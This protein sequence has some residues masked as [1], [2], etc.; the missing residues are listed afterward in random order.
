MGGYNSINQGQYSPPGLRA[1]LFA[2]LLVAA[3]TAIGCA[4]IAVQY[5]EG[6]FEHLAL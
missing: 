1:F 2:L 4:I 6:P 5:I 3:L